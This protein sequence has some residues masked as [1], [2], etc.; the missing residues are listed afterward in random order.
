MAKIQF[1]HNMIFFGV[2][3]NEKQPSRMTLEGSR[4]YTGP[5]HVLLPTILLALIV[6]IPRLS[7]PSAPRN[8]YWDYKFGL[9]ALPRNMSEIVLKGDMSRIL[10]GSG[11]VHGRVGVHHVTFDRQYRKIQ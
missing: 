1:L 3:H 5:I 4:R 10:F 11:A 2:D 8:Q 7:R 9:F 6:P